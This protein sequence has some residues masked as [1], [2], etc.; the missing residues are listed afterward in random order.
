MTYCAIDKE[1]LAYLLRQGTDEYELRK[2]FVDCRV[3]LIQRGAKVQNL[4][5]G[6]T[7]RIRVIVNELPGTAD[8]VLRAWFAENLTM[9]DPEAPESIIETFRLHEEYGEDIDEESAKRLSRSSLVH[10]FSEQPSGILLEFLRSPIGG[11]AAV[12]E[13]AVIAPFPPEFKAIPDLEHLA[14]LLLAL[15]QGQDVDKYLDRVPADLAGLITGLQAAAKG[16]MTEAHAALQAMPIDSPVRGKLDQFIK[17]QEA[18]PLKA[19]PRGVAVVQ[20]DSFDGSFDHDTDEILGY[21]T[22]ATSPNAVF[23]QPMAVL[24]AGVGQRLANEA[25]RELFPANG[26]VMAFPGPAFPR[27]P[28]RGEV[29]VWRVEEHATDKATHF[30][31]K[32]E[33]R[34]VYELLDVPFPSTDYDSV[35]EFIR[36]LAETRGVAQLQQPLF[37]LSDGL[38]VGART[39]K[40]NLSMDESFE[41]GLL[42]W[43]ELG[44]SR[45][46]GRM[47]CIGPLPKEHGIYECSSI[48]VSIRKLLRPYVGSGK[49]LVGLT[50]GQFSE[51][52]QHI[53]SH[54]TDLTAGRLQRIR[55]E[56][57]LLEQSQ[58]G[59]Q[60]LVQELFAH[61]SVRQRIDELVKEA[62]EKHVLEKT[63]IQSDIT[64]LKKERDEWEQKVQKQK[65]EHKK[66]RD[67]TTKVVRA[68]FE[69]ARTESV[70][71]LA[72]LAIFQEL[73]GVTNQDGSPTVF[74]PSIREFS[75]LPT[76]AAT[77]LQKLG[78][79]A[80][81]ASAFALVGELVAKTGLILCVR[82]MASRLVVEQ[83]A[84]SMGKGILID[85]TVG[86]IDDA[87]IKRYFASTWPEVVAVLDAN[88]SPLDIYARPVSD[89]VIAGLVNGGKRTAGLF[90]MSD[91]IGHLPLPRS[92]ERLSLSIDLDANYEFETSDV[93]DSVARVFDSEDGAIAVR[94]WRPACD[95]LK[96]HISALDAERKRLV[97]PMLSGT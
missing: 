76:D 32:A 50:K 59:L 33:T 21:C 28:R 51:L 12:V 39:E 9:S 15:F 26:D 6:D 58:E 62:A 55:S 42:S 25:R 47:F 61:S 84:K 11:R 48:G 49:A 71:T 31:L 88:L 13:G 86:L 46:E 45:F 66:L 44:V 96:E 20:F 56:L 34:K 65:D 64:R 10:L 29:G 97:L 3:K 19:G 4:P 81:R 83:W 54:E 92:F 36:E 2:F 41:S 67:E 73:T 17:Q 43:N 52:V 60:A 35:R 68:A 69:K 23:V 79:S 40:P 90:S 14:Q 93:D 95:K 85:A 30:H 87:P 63:Q 24:R 70:G 80:R 37:V 1:R 57:D 53:E 38:I 78:I 91:S 7:A 77:S 18:R 82:G 16:R 72:E 5:H 22:N 27:Q 75:K 8:D 74:Q 94:L 89:A